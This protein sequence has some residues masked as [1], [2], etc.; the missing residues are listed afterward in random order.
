M[1]RAL[2]S[3]GLGVMT[4]STGFRDIKAQDKFHI[5][6]RKSERQAQSRGRGVWEG[7]E[8]VVWWRRLTRPVYNMFKSK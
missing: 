8:H 5:L 4:E 1:N 2:L 6:L 7:S 3:A